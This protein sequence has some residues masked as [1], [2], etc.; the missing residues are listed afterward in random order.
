M[1]L[2]CHPLDRIP[3]FATLALFCVLGSKC[4]TLYGI[5][6]ARDTPFSEASRAVFAVLFSRYI[7]GTC[8][9]TSLLE[10]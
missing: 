6:E 8:P 3:Y 1:L 4:L 5:E 2:A 7:E 10:G 9:Q